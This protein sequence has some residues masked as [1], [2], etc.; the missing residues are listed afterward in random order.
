MS[1]SNV[2]R[3]P[4]TP[5]IRVTCEE[6]LRRCQIGDQITWE[7]FEKHC[8]TPRQGIYVPVSQARRA[9]AKTGVHFITRHGIG[10]ERLSDADVIGEVC[11]RDARRIQRSGRKLRRTTESVAVLSLP[12]DV[13]L[14][15]VAYG[16]LGSMVEAAAKPKAI[17]KLAAVQD[18]NQIARKSLEPA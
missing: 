2:R 1:K 13:R 7:D 4:F 12:Q 10:V 16:E 9:L 3:T 11:P 17:K 14:M 18:I 15:A 8:G 6:L 5:A